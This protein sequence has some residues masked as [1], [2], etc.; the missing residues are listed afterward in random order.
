MSLQIIEQLLSWRSFS[1]DP[2]VGVL[3]DNAAAMIDLMDNALTQITNVPTESPD[4]ALIM[5]GIAS[6]TLAQIGAN[7]LTTVQLNLP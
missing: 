1:T 6:S 3:C 7:D 4:A 5:Q 2:Q